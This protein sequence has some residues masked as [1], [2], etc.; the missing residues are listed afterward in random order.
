MT[1]TARSRIRETQYAV[2]GQADVI[3]IIYVVPF[4]CTLLQ[5]DCTYGD[6]PNAADVFKIWKVGGEDPFGRIAPIIRIFNMGANEWK[7]V[8]CNEPF[9]FQKGDVLKIT[10]GNADDLN[11]GVEAIFQEAG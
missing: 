6:T 9:Y 3:D 7:T 1:Y 5:V 8:I 2:A 4:N 10:A 11:I